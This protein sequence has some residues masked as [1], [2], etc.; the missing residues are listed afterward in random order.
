MWHRH[1]QDCLSHAAHP[2]SMLRRRATKHRTPHATFTKCVI[3]E[4]F[5]WALVFWIDWSRIIFWQA[6]DFLPRNF[7]RDPAGHLL[8]Y[9]NTKIRKRRIWTKCTRKRPHIKWFLKNIP[10]HQPCE[11]P[12]AGLFFWQAPY[13]LPRIFFQDPA[14]HLLPYP[15][16]VFNKTY[17]CTHNRDKLTELYTTSSWFRTCT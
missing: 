17:K 11:F 14:E 5:A 8:P 12:R 13:F 1:L 4:D 10:F 15:I 9:P 16:T 7:F 6:S 2:T 3:C